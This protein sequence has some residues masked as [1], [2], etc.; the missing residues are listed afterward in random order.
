MAHRETT[1]NR[2]PGDPGAPGDKK[3]IFVEK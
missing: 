2:N 3:N 1:Q